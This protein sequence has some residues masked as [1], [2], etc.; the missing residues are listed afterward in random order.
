MAGRI[1]TGRLGWHD[2]WVTIPIFDQDDDLQGVFLR[3]GPQAEKACGLRFTQAGGQRSMLYCP[4]WALL[5][6][7][8]SVAVVF[9]MFDALTLAELRIPVVTVTGGDRT[10][11]PYHLTQIRSRC[12]IIPDK[13]A[14]GAAAELAAGLGWRGKIKRLSYPNGLTDINDYVREGRAGDLLREIGNEF[15]E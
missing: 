9:G 12:I 6:D 7:K 10:F 2:G 11:T 3:A 13:K 15:V 4:D 14:S 1:E 8:K 5:R